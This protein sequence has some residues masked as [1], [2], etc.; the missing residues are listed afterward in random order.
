MAL[1]E[2]R[3]VKLDKLNKV[4]D[5][6]IDPYPS[7][8]LRTHMAAEALEGFTELEKSGEKIIIAGRVMTKRE[9]GGS[10]FL[11]VVDNSGKLQAYIK[12]DN[13]GEEDFTFFVNTVDVGDFIES[14]GVVFR[15]KKGEETLEV[16]KYRLLAKSLLPLPE[17]WHG[18]QDIEERYRKRY[19]DFVFN[20]DAK[21]KII[22]RSMVTQHI[23]QY[24]IANKFLEVDTPVL[25]TLYGGANAKPF[26][27][28]LAI[29]DLDLYLRIAPELF[30]K[31]MLVGGFE[32]VFEIGRVFRNEGFD[33]EHNPEFTMLEFYAAYWDY[34][35]M[36]EFTEGMLV[37]IVKEM[38]GKDR[39]Q[40]QEKEIEF[41]TPFKRVTFNDLFNEY[42]N[43]DYD[44]STQE[45]LAEKAKE[46]GIE[47]NKAMTKGN[48]ADEIYKK[49]ARPNILN[50][51]YIIDHPLEISPLSKK[52]PD[53]PKHVARFQLVV[54]GMEV[55]NGF[56]ELNDPQDQRER[57]E[58]Q[59]KN[60]KEGN[61]EA[62]RIDEDY[63]EAMEYG[64]PP[65][66]GIGIGI[67][68]LSALLTDSHS[69]REV[70]AFPLM[71]PRS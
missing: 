34:E 14:E 64:M 66:A 16:S 60:A 49:V 33:R 47:I 61:E 36:M 2:L 59:E 41:K 3:Q 46:L 42:A 8:S 10:V 1:D 20:K 44:S 68:R 12:K 7:S 63:I 27:T 40:Y 54:G 37:H 35:K 53:D 15:T 56:S 65:A 51:T 24:L 17:K 5:N 6:G 13:L 23:R 50:P 55:T 48:I 22:G 25:Q 52:I 39:V 4:R 38:F 29:L 69:I 45:E 19:L 21:D 9:H 58:A 26:K 57:F 18:L 70:I 43:L 71:K 30:L 28:K 62:H 67:D 32:R 11:D 31:R